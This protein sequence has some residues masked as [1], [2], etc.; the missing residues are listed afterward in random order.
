[1]VSVLKQNFK[2]E[3]LHN[4]SDDKTTYIK[5]VINRKERIENEQFDVVQTLEIKKTKKTIKGTL[6]MVERTKIKKFGECE[7][8]SRGQ[9]EVG[10]VRE[11]TDCRLVDR[12]KAVY[13]ESLKDKLA[14]GN[15]DM[16]KDEIVERILEEMDY[17][18]Q[19]RN[20][21]NTKKEVNERKER[22]YKDSEIKISGFDMTYDENDLIKI[23]SAVGDVKKCIILRARKDR[24]RKLNIAYL[25][26]HQSIHVKEA[27]TKFDNTD[28]GMGTMRVCR[29]KDD[30]F[31][32]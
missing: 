20:K 2:D 22:T 27:I 11:D 10:I 18:R 19:M 13:Q 12:I 9:V 29:P 15:K 5:R 4:K 28:S 30:E 23:F 16:S 8:Q 21:M 17:E 32:Y 1:M 7:G 6:G 25:T 14:S 24:S 3:I 31:F 26:F